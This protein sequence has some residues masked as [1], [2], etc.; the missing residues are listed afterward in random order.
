MKI[1]LYLIAAL[2]LISS[3]GTCVM[4]KSSLHETLGVTLLIVAMLGFGFGAVIEQVERL[5]SDVTKQFSYLADFL[6]ERIK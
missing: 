1:F 3:L 4:A 2:A 5:N 6:K